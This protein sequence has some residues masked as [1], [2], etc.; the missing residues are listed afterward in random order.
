MPIS[1]KKGRW[2]FNVLTIFF[3]FDRKLPENVRMCYQIDPVGKHFSWLHVICLSKSSC[4]DTR[5]RVISHKR[6]W[7][8]LSLTE[9][10]SELYRRQSILME[11]SDQL[12]V[13]NTK[14]KLI[15]FKTWEENP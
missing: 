9:S 6:Q 7:D 10:E 13:E 2:R 14:E 12:C 1:E 15:K 8:N 5:P 4:M 3:F 11:T